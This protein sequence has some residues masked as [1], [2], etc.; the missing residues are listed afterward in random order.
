MHRLKLLISIVIVCASH[1]CIAVKD[2]TVRTL[3]ALASAPEALRSRELK[4]LRSVRKPHLIFL[5]VICSVLFVP[6]PQR[7]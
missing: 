2:I 1:E 6:D 4:P 5:Q 3:A 7:A